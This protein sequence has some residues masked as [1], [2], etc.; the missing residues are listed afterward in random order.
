MYQPTP[1]GPGRYTLE[2]PRFQHTDPPPP[3]CD[4][5]TA[6]A[7]D[8]G[9][10][11]AFTDLPKRRKRHGTPP[12]APNG[13]FEWTNTTPKHLDILR[14]LRFHLGIKQ[15]HLPE[16]PTTFETADFSALADIFRAIRACPSDRI[17]QWTFSMILSSI[18]AEKDSIFFMMLIDAAIRLLDADVTALAHQR[19]GFGLFEQFH[20]DALLRLFVCLFVCLIFKYFSFFFFVFVVFQ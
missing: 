16:I 19:V 8:P 12:P 17:R 6:L 10:H 2:S 9:S 1:Y 3:I 14:L 5:H 11:S 15:G 18:K 7:S 4:L 20:D 13:P